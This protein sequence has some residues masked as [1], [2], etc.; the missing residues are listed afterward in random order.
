MSST[1]DGDA[2]TDAMAT[3]LKEAAS[4]LEMIAAENRRLEETFESQGW[5]GLD[6]L[7]SATQEI[8]TI[9]D[10]LV[11]VAD[12]IGIGGQIVRDTLLSNQMITHATKESLIPS[13]NTGDSH[14]QAAATAI[15]AHLTTQNALGMATESTVEQPTAPIGSTGWRL[16]AVATSK[17]GVPC[18]HCQRV[19]KRLFTV[20]D[21]NDRQMVVGRGCVKKLTGW[22]LEIAEA[23]RLLKWAALQAHRAAAWSRFA[24]QHAELAALIDADIAAFERIT[25]QHLA[26]SGSGSHEMKNWICDGRMTGAFLDSR[27]TD[28]LRR[29]RTF[30]WT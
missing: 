2:G 17:T 12:K 20:R 9:G 21:L 11:L 15:G 5:T 27:I 19:L 29:R 6:I 1:L 18:D 8:R 28:Y 7:S 3:A 25:P 26:A 16:V 4:E 13:S 14:T 22:T 30:A 10:G 24:T 23:E